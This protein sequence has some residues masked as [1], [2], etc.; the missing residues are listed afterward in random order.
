MSGEAGTGI[1]THNDWRQIERQAR[2]RARNCAQRASE[3]AE[4][5]NPVASREWSEAEQAALAAAREAA[6]GAEGRSSSLR[7]RIGEASNG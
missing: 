1:G 2:D 6:S 7:E 3:A 5:G 4:H